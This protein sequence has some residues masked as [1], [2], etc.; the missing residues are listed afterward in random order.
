M[1]AG[2]LAFLP[3]VREAAADELIVSDGFSCREQVAQTSERQVLHLADVLW[4]AMHHDP[5]V[6][7][8]ERPEL[9]AMPDMPQRIARA[10]RDGFALIGVAVLAACCI[11]GALAWGRNS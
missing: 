5:S 10:H 9:L 1:K 8:G 11:A 7:L 6:P 3:H 2:E 4:L